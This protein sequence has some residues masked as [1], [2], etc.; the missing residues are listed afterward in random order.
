[1][2]LEVNGRRHTLT[3]EPRTTLLDALREELA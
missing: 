2:T 1:M 3:V